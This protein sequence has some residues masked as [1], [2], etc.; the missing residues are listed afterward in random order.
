MSAKVL[1]ALAVT[2]EL[3]GAEFSETALRVVVQDLSAYP[4]QV[5]LH[6]LDRCRR[7]LR[8]R[9]T[10]GAILER[11]EEADGRPGADEAWA[12]AIRA[13][14]EAETVVWTDEIAQAFAVAQPILEAR[15]KVGAR[16][17]FRDAYERIVRDSRSG[18]APARW[19]VSAGHD[20]ERRASA[21][22]AAIALRRIDAPS[23]QQLM[24]APGESRVIA[25]L[26]SSNAPA[27]LDEP[28]LD[29]ADRDRLIRGAEGVRLHLSEL[30]RLH[31]ERQ[32][33]F[34]VRQAEEREHQARRRAERQRMIAEYA[35]RRGVDLKDSAS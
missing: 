31:D 23:V 7:E 2:A 35:A 24:P 28:G 10:F 17:A 5:V 11:I 12:I 29:K 1:K 33:V 9:L 14:D 18:S 21:L 15:D 30:D 19:I 27:L 8:G 16:M 22:S 26:I 4:E 34:E 20:P 6:A 13:Q 25:A 3:T 32:D